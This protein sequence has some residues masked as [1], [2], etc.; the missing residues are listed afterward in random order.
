[1]STAD[2]A[3]DGDPADLA[4]QRTPLVEDDETQVDAVVD[5][6]GEADPADVIEQSI[7]VG[8]D[9]EGYERS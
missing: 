2:W 5:D 6:I 9:E 4:E 8:G 3:A 7:A 1:M